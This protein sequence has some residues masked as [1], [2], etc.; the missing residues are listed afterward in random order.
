MGPD[1]THEQMMWEDWA[2]KVQPG[3]RCEAA[4]R[5]ATVSA[6]TDDFLWV[7]LDGRTDPEPFEW[8]DVGPVTT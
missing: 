2:G 8:C 4:F 5:P 6:V 7:I 1:L 3:D